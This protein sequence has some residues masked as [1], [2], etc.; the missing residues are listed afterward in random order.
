MI[1]SD[2]TVEYSWFEIRMAKILMGLE[3]TFS[4]T[5]EQLHE[6]KA[7]WETIQE[8]KKLARSESPEMAGEVA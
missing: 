3:G 6:R 8:L 1:I 4:R 2:E 7:L 5:T